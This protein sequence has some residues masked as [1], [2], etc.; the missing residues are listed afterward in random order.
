M[1]VENLDYDVGDVLDCDAC[2]ICNV[3]TGSA[4]VNCLVAVHDELLLELEHNPERLGLDDSVAEGDRFRVDGI[5]VTG[6]SDDIEVP[7]AAANC[8]SSETNGAVCEALA[9]VKF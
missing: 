9:V 3:N 2:S 7:I 1:D 5:V 4:A 8:V 6:V